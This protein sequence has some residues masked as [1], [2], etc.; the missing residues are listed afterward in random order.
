M[1]CCDVLFVY[2][3]EY[4]HKKWKEDDFFGYQYLNGTNPVMIKKCKQIPSN[5][6]VTNSMVSGFLEK[7]SSLQKEMEKG[8][9]FLVDYQLL[10]DIPANTIHGRTQYIAAPLCLLY[11]DT[12]NKLKPIAIQLKQTADPENPIFLPNDKEEDWLLAKI[13]VRSADFN[14][15][16]LDAHL[17]R[18]HL[19]A[20][21]FCMATLRHLASVHPLYKL[22]IPHMRYTL[23]INIMA[24]NNLINEGGLFDKALSTGGNGMFK[25]LQKAQDSMTYSSLCL[26]DD[27]KARGVE[28]IPCYYYRDDGI[29]LWAVINRFVQSLLKYYYPND[30]D[31]LEDTE[32]QGWIN[33]IFCEGFLQ[34]EESGIPNSFSTVNELNKFLTM[35]IFTCSVQHSAVN[36]G[37][38]DFCAWV[39]N[40]SPTM[41]RPPPTKKGETTM[42]DIFQ[43]IADVG[44]TVD[45]LA[46][47]WLLSS[48]FSDFIKLGDY[49]AKRFTEEYPQ[50]MID[51]FQLD[52]KKID[53]EIAH[54]NKGQEF[55]YT[56][57]RPSLMENSVA[58]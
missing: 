43:S 58:I 21:V 38:F 45:I 19:L 50:K 42:E 54:R 47:I 5:F 10:D 51:Q 20:E 56:Y 33:D 23:Q 14:L 46:A 34:R 39:L 17:L 9:I 1:Q 40:A 25:V 18:T 29:K 30:S 52:L 11:K 24:R 48:P 27:I 3:P 4:V 57:M 26:P 28:D 32:L 22:L 8:N 35:V 2:N 7:S 13:F 37:Q 31:V 44:S 55:G 49:P 15:F 16:E 41:Q 36:S 6:P 53:K 12:H